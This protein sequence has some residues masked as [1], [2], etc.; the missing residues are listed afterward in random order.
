MLTQVAE[1][2]AASTDKVLHMRFN[3]I[4]GHCIACETYSICMP[5][6]DWLVVGW[7]ANKIV[8][9]TKNFIKAVRCNLEQINKIHST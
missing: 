7:L 1:Y 5:L 8:T 4:V 2:L 9:N 3:L 6:L